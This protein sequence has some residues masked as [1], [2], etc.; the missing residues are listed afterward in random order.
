VNEWNGHSTVSE[1]VINALRNAN[2]LRLRVVNGSLGLSYTDLD[3]VDLTGIL[4][5]I[6]SFLGD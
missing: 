2:V 5:R 6:K 4:P 3:D 1:N